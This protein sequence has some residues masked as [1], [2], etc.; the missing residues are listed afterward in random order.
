MTDS[1]TNAILQGYVI[2]EHKDTGILIAEKQIF[3][4]EKEIIMLD[5]CQDLVWDSANG[6]ILAD[7]NAI[8]MKGGRRL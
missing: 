8:C 5:Q 3:F 2:S 4:P 1:N 7:N 6:I